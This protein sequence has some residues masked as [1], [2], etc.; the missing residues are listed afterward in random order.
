MSEPATSGPAPRLLFLVG[1]SGSGKSTVGRLLAERWG[2]PF[3]DTDTEIERETG[4]TIPQFF[5]EAGEAAFRER[6]RSVLARLAGLPQAVVATGGGLPVDPENRRVMRRA[7]VEVWLDALTETLVSRLEQDDDHSRPLLSEDLQ[8]GLERQRAARSSAYCEAHLRIETSGRTSAEV[9]QEI[10]GATAPSFEPVWVEAPSR[11]YP[12]YVGPGALSRAAALLRAHGL[13][14][15]LRIIADERVAALHGDAVREALAEFPTAWYTV[16]AGEEH[17]TLEQAERLYDGLLADRI[18]RRDVIVA[19]GGGV[20]GD[21]AGFVAS[22]ILRGVRFVQIPTTV[23][24]QVDS[25][26]GGKVGVDHPRGK[27]LIGAFH[28][29]SLVLADVGV[30]RTLPPREIAAGWAEVVKIAVI[31]DADFFHQLEESADRLT[32][33]ESGATGRAIRR[34]VELKAHV[35]AQDEYDLTGARA[36][37]NYGH[38]LGHALEAATEYSALLHGEGVAIGMAGAAHIAEKLELHPHD[39]VERQSSLLQRLGLPDTAPGVSA[40]AVR[41]ALGLDK[42]RAA[43]KIAWIV[44]AGL[45][46]VQVTKEVPGSLVEEA[47]SLITGTRHQ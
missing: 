26:V 32:S 34:S 7:G 3:F 17:K 44:P 22:T 29:P 6:E 1:L 19:L 20:I 40:Q 21:L 45:G 30:L 36:I 27:N 39:A 16:P 28:Q 11:T 8:A 33:L 43:G 25:S 15:P 46:H 31:Q 38:T 9:A 2:V 35:V 23:L 10:A 24:S 18:E 47:I 14:A 12:V 37:L 13:D 5:A 4:R 42:K 41:D